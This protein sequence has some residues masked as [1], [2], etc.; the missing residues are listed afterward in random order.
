MK[1]CTPYRK[2]S[3]YSTKA[4]CLRKAHHVCRILYFFTT[5]PALTLL[6]TETN[7]NIKNKSYF[8]LCGCALIICTCLTQNSGCRQHDHAASLS[9]NNALVLT[10]VL[11]TRPMQE[12]CMTLLIQNGSS[13][14]Q[15]SEDWFIY[16]AMS[17]SQCNQIITR[18]STTSSTDVGSTSHG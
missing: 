8:T 10:R 14:Q 16:A 1:V 17:V 2:V 11:E 18:K 9:R 15:N 4:S 7:S 12:F 6:T 3:H 5:N 13:T